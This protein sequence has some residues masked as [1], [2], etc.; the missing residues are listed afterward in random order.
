MPRASAADAALTARR[1]LEAA[2]AL[3][4]ARGF[5]DVAL[6]DVARAA[7]VT[8][9]AVYH[10][11]GSKTR[12]FAAVV[13]HLQAHVAAAIVAAAADPGAGGRTAGPEERLRA[14]SHA[15]LDA[16]TSDRT[17]RVLLIDAPAVLG[18]QEWRRLDAEHAIVELRDALAD[19]GIADDLRDALA[20][21]LSGAMNDAALWIAQHDD[22][23]T[24]RARAHAALNRLLAAALIAT[25]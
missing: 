2:A 20:A 8:R 3:F 18:W 23:E 10:H 9:G 19:V 13:E 6:D 15:F 25:D 1:L 21:Q 11:Y 17:V 24:A 5:A 22:P 7:G 16:V 4:G 12:L 14:G